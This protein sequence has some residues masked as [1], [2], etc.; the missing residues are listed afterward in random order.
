MGKAGLVRLGEYLSLE[1]LDVST[2]SLIPR[3]FIPER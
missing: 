3:L 2:Q 1:T